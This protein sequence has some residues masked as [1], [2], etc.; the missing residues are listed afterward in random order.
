MNQTGTA[1]GWKCFGITT[2]DRPDRSRRLERELERVGL[3][4]SILRTERLGDAGG[5]ASTG[6]HGCFM[7]HLESLRAA[8]SEGV[9]VAVIVEDD[10][11][12]VRSFRR[13]LDQ[14]I[15]ELAELDWSMLYLGYL[16]D[17]S[18]IGSEPLHL[19]SDHIAQAEGWEVT[20]GH[21]VAIRREAL[22]S[23][24][25]DFERRLLP[26]GHRISPDG[27][28]NE[29]RRD[30]GLPTL[31]A[32]PNLARQGPSPSGITERPGL[33]SRLLER[34][35]VSAVAWVAK[36]QLWELSSSVPPR[37]W[38]RLWNVR[39]RTAGRPPATG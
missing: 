9:D 28:L 24:I 25:A 6:V 36:R 17:S 5:F 39:S 15:S 13:R 14:L 19:L 32:L 31:V 16:A 37:L 20:G 27:V 38:E 33:R 34:P 21:F 35:T 2:I 22:D 10:A 18:P 12:V 11:V 1:T 29:W 30:E 7:S 23:V 8:R 4:Y 26:G 3:P